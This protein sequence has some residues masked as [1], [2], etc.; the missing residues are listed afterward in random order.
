MEKYKDQWH[1][2]DVH[3]NHEVAEF[4]HTINDQFYLGTSSAMHV[5]GIYPQFYYR[6]SV[7]VPN[8]TF[9]T[10][11]VSDNYVYLT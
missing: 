10:S 9:V 5:Y 7:P 3:P 2:L 4:C 1:L 6:G 11:F 8:S